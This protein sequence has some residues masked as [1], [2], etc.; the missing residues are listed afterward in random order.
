M[1]KHNMILELSEMLDIEAEKLVETADL[2]ELG[3]D[4][5]TNL[6][7]MSFADNNFNVVISPK[8]LSSAKSVSDI[9]S[10]VSAHLED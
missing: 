6:A 9:L 2:S 3:W 10:L 1:T 7:F 8:D 4:S 5:L